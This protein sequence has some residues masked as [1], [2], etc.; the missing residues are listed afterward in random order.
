MLCKQGRNFKYRSDLITNPTASELLFKRRLD[1]LGINYLFQKGFIKGDFHCIVDFYLPKPLKICI[2]IDGSVH[3]TDQQKKRDF[4][5]DEYLRS[6]GF[7]VIRIK[8]E[9]VLN[10]D[11]NKIV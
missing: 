6:R 9:D 4:R 11:L 8:N 2:E 3:D 10:F 7:K 5:K 1:E